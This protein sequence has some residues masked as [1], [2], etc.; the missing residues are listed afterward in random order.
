MDN[1]AQGLEEL[2]ILHNI[3]ELVMG[4]AADRHFSKYGSKQPNLVFLIT[5]FSKIGSRH[6]MT[7]Y[8][9]SVILSD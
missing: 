7:M 2:I 5:L 1:V 9:P 3:T 4:A 8:L 6:K